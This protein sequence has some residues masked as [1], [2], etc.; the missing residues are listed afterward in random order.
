MRTQPCV[1]NCRS[2]ASESSAGISELTAALDSIASKFVGFGP[3]FELRIVRRLEL[4][5]LV[6]PLRSRLAGREAPVLTMIVPVVGI[7]GLRA[8]EMFLRQLRLLRIVEP[9]RQSEIRLGVHFVGRS[10]LHA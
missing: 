3:Q 4:L 8:L 9:H 10:R 1:A 6:E 2:W 7:Q 5:E